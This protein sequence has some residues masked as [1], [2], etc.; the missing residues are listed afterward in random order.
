MLRIYVTPSYNTLRIS[1]FKSHQTIYESVQTIW[2]DNEG[3]P[4]GAVY[5]KLFIFVNNCD[6]RGNLNGRPLR[7]S[8]KC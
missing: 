4:P 8:V 7:L 6:N 3:G 1:K 2:L 5:V